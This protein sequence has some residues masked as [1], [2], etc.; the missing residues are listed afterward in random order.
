MHDTRLSSQ[1]VIATD[2]DT[3]H[4][5]VRWAKGGAARFHFQWLRDNC[6]SDHRFDRKTGGRKALTES[7][8]ADLG[9]KDI[10]IENGGLRIA[11]SDE[12][13]ESWFDPDWLAKNAYDP[14]DRPSKTRPE[15]RGPNTPAR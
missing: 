1:G 6:R 4:L 8:A 12:E 2:I 9:A 13:T 10:Q 11:W 15:P 5:T 14:G 7:I 3:G